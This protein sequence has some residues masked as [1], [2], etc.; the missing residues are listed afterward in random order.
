LNTSQI[1]SNTDSTLAPDA[2]IA[3]VQGSKSLAMTVF[4]YALAL[5]AI[6]MLAKLV[7]HLVTI[8]QTW[9][10]TFMQ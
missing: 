9:R 10:S 3:P 8:W 7:L 6:V 2:E 1:E 5:A 4:Q